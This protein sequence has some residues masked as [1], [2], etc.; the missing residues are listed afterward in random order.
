MRTVIYLDSLLLINFVIGWFLLRA[1]GLL[2]GA[3]PPSGR[4]LAGAVLAALSTL[5][6]LAPV[7]PVPAQLAYQLATA[8]CVV[9]AAF[10]WRGLRCFA[11]GTFWYFALNLGL[12]GLVI[13][14]L[15]RGGA[16]GMHTNNL[17]VYFD[18]SPMLLLV[19]TL[20]VYGMAKL[21]A[22]VF[23][24]PAGEPLWAL[25]LEMDGV[26]LRG[27][28]L[29]DPYTGRPVVLMSWP[30]VTGRLPAELER[31]L[32]GW[33]SGEAGAV[34]PPGLGVR[35]LQCGTAVGDGLLPGVP[36]K[37]VRLTC[38]GRTV[39]AGP[40][41]LVFAGRRLADGRYDALLGPELEMRPIKNDTMT[42]EN[43]A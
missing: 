31:Y 24:C 8:L 2:A 33:F 17:A 14:A 4:T 23:G 18:V 15:T 19:C 13:L 34:P 5:I 12:A 28:A 6:L 40:V 10:P 35:L 43:R 9:R 29:R 27:L 22:A 11:R 20:S 32:T 25:E 42:E 36:V 21:A 16:A 3:L 30:A 38:G 26:I 1:A 7:M 37:Q 39:C 41:V